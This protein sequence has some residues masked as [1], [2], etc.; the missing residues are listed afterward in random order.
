MRLTDE[1]IRD[2]LAA[3]YVVGTLSAR[4]RR[5][6]QSLMR[7]DPQLRLRVEA[8]EERLDP[9]ADALPDHAPP[10]RLWDAIAERIRPARAR[11]AGDPAR[12]VRFWRSVAFVMSVLLVAGMIH[13]GVERADPRPD[14]MAVLNDAKSEAA[15]VVSWPL[16][17]AE[18]KVVR[19]R[20]MTPAALPPD[21]SWELWLIPSD[22]M[23]RPLSAGLMRM[24]PDQ[25]L[26]ISGPAAGALSKAWGFA[27]SVE[28]R[29]GSP[30]GAPTGPV[31]FRG[32][33]VRLINA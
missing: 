6:L 29:G 1:R 30:T 11:A 31:I 32:P 9:F 28:P 4:V 27:V 15:L 20:I 33:C 22:R 13:L 2:A 17:Q 19:V 24:T 10:P 5:R 14:M 18:R 26:E 12:V 16:Q 25:T 8:W 3:Q 7:Y 23:D 21:V